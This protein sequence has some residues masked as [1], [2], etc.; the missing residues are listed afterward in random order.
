MD[1]DKHD[2]LIPRYVDKDA[3]RCHIAT[4]AGLIGKAALAVNDPGFIQGHGA[5][6]DNVDLQGEVMRRGAFAK[7]IKE[8]I[9]T[10]KVK[11]MVKHFAHGGDV[12]ELIGT[13]TKAEEDAK[14]LFFHADLAKT[15]LAQETRQLVMDGHVDGAS[16]GFMP[17]QWGFIKVG[18]LEDI[19]EHKESKLFEITVTVMPAN[20]LARLTGAKTLE[21]ALDHL[22]QL[23]KQF[24]ELEGSSSQSSEDVDRLLE[25]HL[26][27]REQAQSVSKA[28]ADMLVRSKTMA[29]PKP[30]GDPSPVLEVGT[31]RIREMHMRLQKSKTDLNRLRSKLVK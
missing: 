25:E 30:S 20:E 24:D 29:T 4:D 19:I 7:S 22:G 10:G 9:P 6:W 16:V 17:I 13:I 5:V 21:A 2:V 8:R 27:G 18:E 1:K 26:G 28:L 12:M 31:D 23:T 15:Q 3:R 11:L 14:G